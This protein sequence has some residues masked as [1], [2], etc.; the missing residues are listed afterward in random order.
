[1]TVSSLPDFP[2]EGPLT[3]EMENQVAILTLNRP[4]RGNAIS[5]DMML[6]LEEA[7]A[8][9]QPRRRLSAWSS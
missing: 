7:W 4:E 5:P 6:A 2:A 9:G 8:L 3:I 1:V